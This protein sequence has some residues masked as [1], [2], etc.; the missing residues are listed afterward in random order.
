MSKHVLNTR[1]TGAARE[2]DRECVRA[3]AVQ[4]PRNNP[5]V[6][7]TAGEQ[8]RGASDEHHAVEL[9]FYAFVLTAGR[10]RLARE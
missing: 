9:S 7:C 4:L 5:A 1:L 2:G 8:R 3:N 6:P 10:L